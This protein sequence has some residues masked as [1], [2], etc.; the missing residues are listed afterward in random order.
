LI[1]AIL[2]SV[3]TWVVDGVDSSNPQARPVVVAD[4][5]TVHSRVESSSPR[6]RGMN[7]ASIPLA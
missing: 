3:E 4:L 5:T 2:G 6:K 1:G 7:V